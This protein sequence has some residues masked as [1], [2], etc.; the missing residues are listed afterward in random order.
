MDDHCSAQH[1]LGKID[2]M[3]GGV[4]VDTSSGTVHAVAC[5]LDNLTNLQRQL[6]AANAT[7]EKQRQELAAL[8]QG[9]GEWSTSGNLGDGIIRDIN[10]SIVGDAMITAHAKPL[11]AAH[12]A[13]MAGLKAKL[14]EKGAANTRMNQAMGDAISKATRLNFLTDNWKKKMQADSVERIR[15]QKERDDTDTYNRVLM[16]ENAELRASGGKWST[17]KEYG[18][19]IKVADHE[20]ITMAS[21]EMKQAALIVAEHNASLGVEPEWEY[22]VVE[23]KIGGSVYSAIK[24]DNWQ[25]VDA[26]DLSRHLSGEHHYPLHVLRR[27]KPVDK[28]E[29]PKRETAYVVYKAVP[30]YIED[31]WDVDLDKTPHDFGIY[32]CKRK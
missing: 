22:G 16:K 1:T 24:D 17:S 26:Y 6:D 8:K 30:E 27:P 3:L 5:A 23:T 2:K 12:N 14:T 18:V 13:A 7:I 29:K 28:V 4:A 10:M 20:Y 32:M 19:C 31:G 11:V 25:P 15:L 9:G 21:D